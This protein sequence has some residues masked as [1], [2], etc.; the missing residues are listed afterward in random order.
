MEANF[1]VRKQTV[2]RT[3]FNYT[4]RKPVTKLTKP[5]LESAADSVLSLLSPLFLKLET[6]PR[7]C[8]STVDSLGKP[9]RPMSQAEA[10]A[11]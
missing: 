1:D 6:R 5:S 3:Q 4:L 10:Q 9:E 11:Q 8:R 2:W 7:W